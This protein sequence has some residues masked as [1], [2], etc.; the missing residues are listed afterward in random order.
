MTE[1]PSVLI[2]EDTKELVD[3]LYRRFE[4]DYT[5]HHAYNGED[6]LVAA[7]SVRPDIVLLDI[8]M[9]KMSGFEVL[10]E[11]RSSEATRD[12]P[13]LVLTAL[14]D[15]EN[16]VKGFNLGA[17]DYV[18]KPFNFVELSARIKAHITIKALQKRLIDLER[19]NT[20]R[21]VAVSFDHEINNPLTSITIFAHF[22]KD[23]L[24][25]G[26][27]DSR[28]SVAGIAAEVERIADIVKKLSAATKAATIDYQPG[29]KM[30]DFG[31]LTK[32][33]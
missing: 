31:H 12:I 13:V 6:G 15:T 4:K 25:D 22:L 26:D 20:L 3:L 33:D 9:P 16:V 8:T 28:K 7:R 24:A 17:A 1:K 23:K 27:E 29:V 14:S 18:V 10:S 21:E 32:E 30:I 5:L 19:L 2:I 11:L